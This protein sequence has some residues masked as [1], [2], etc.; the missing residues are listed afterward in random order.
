MLAARAG[1]APP[2]GALFS[3]TVGCNSCP[4]KEA[5][6]LAQVS[7]RHARLHQASSEPGRVVGGVTTSSLARSLAPMRVQRRA[8]IRCGMLGAEPLSFVRGR[9]WGPDGP[10]GRAG[11]GREGAA[12][13]SVEFWS[14]SW[15]CWARRTFETVAFFF[16]LL[17]QEEKLP[18]SVRLLHTLESEVRGQGFSLFWLDSFSLSSLIFNVFSKCG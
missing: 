6:G 7:L 15:H 5:A 8:V 12:R 2:E 3:R 11:T 14:L 17:S 4:G 10:R 16:F 13:A 1:R 18:C 9:R